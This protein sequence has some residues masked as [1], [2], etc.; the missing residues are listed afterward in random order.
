MVFEFTYSDIPRLFTLVFLE[1][2]L[3]ADN[4][5]VLGALAHGLSPP[6]R[7]KA[8][9]VGLASSFFFRAIALLLAIFFYKNRVIQLIGAA[10]LIYLS[11]RYF[12][13]KSRSQPPTSPSFWKTVFLIEAFDLI[14][15]LDS[16]VAGIAFIDGAPSRLWMVYV[17]GVVGLIGMRFAAH[18]FGLLLDRFPHI[19]KSAYLLVGWIGIKLGLAA[20]S[21]P[22]SPLLF[23][24]FTAFL[25]LYGF[26]KL[27]T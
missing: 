25:F 4:A 21:L 3:S 15:A 19:E 5:I 16:I 23:W 8:L 6:L 26:A 7:R 12:F 9:L 24:V 14:F 27:R 10:Y 1:F 17:G 11:A 2:L 22:L 20:F 18:L 13:R